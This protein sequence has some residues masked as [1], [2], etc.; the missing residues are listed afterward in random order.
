MRTGPQPPPDSA[1]GKEEAKYCAVCAVPLCR[2]AV[3]IAIQWN[4]RD[5]N[6]GMADSVSRRLPTKEKIHSNSS[7][8]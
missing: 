7:T 8:M 2:L 3:M 5:G 1:L 4:A 6:K